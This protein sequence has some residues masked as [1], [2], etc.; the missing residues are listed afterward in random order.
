MKTEHPWLSKT[1]NLLR[2]RRWIVLAVALALVAIVLAAWFVRLATQP[3]R[4]ASERIALDAYG[5]PNV[6]LAITYPITLSPEA[7][8]PHDTRVTISAQALQPDAVAPLDL[9]L[10]L[11]DNAVGFV[12]AQGQH[13]A[14]RLIVVPGYPD[15]LPY[16]LYLVHNNTQLRGGLFRSYRVEIVPALRSADRA[17]PIT[18]LAFRLRLASLFS[19]GLRSLA[20]VVVTRGAPFLLVAAVVAAAAW[21]TYHL[22]R[23]QRLRRERLLALTYSRLREH[24]KLQRWTD[25]RSEIERLRLER[26]H[27]RDI[28]QLD[29]VV[30]AAETA[31]WRR[32]QLYKAGLDA[33]RQR[34]WP[35]AVQPF[36]AIEQETP[37]YRDVR[38]LRRTAALYADL[39]SRDRSRRIAAARELGEVADL[40]DMLPLIAALGDPSAE[41]AAASQE[42]LRQIGIAAVDDLL[43]G[44][45]HSNTAVRESS[46]R[47]LQRLGQSAREP[48]LGALHSSDSQITR[49]AAL[50]L[51]SL[52]ALRELARS[53]H[54]AP[55]SHLEGLVIALQTEPNP[56]ASAL[57]E[58]L[59]Q[60]PV[61]R[62]PV[63]VS[64]LA[65]L[66]GSADVDQRLEEA[67][68]GS[69]SPEKRAL[70]QQAIAAP[71]APFSVPAAASLPPVQPRPEIAA[72]A[73]APSRTRRMLWRRQDSQADAA[74][75]AQSRRTQAQ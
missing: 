44:L 39:T 21:L 42:A 55:E 53:L 18:E 4:H 64:A 30:S 43:G 75:G 7:S 36:S 15:A 14:G 49:Q 29:T 68:R 12:D 67:L 70:L 25:A 1:L 47:L 61:A 17:A 72:P 57:V 5:Y 46:Y 28:D 27:Y 37:Y 51:A 63:M 8:S 40:V 24:I 58:A 11:P 50:L 10:T 23:Q 3:L 19:L 38:F 71:A 6:A 52:G 60:A 22:T 32:E 54:W 33:Y 48:L 62:R 69:R 13:T 74:S 45:V 73:A 9:A 2:E 65:A 16:D 31:A 35:A 34:D 26:G 41:V 59:L 20:T 66:K 56:A